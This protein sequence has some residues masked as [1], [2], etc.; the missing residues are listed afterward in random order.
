MAKKLLKEN[1][2]VVKSLKKSMNL[3][4]V[5][6]EFEENG[7][8]H[9]S[10]TDKRGWMGIVDQQ[11]RTV[12]E[13]YYFNLKY[14]PALPEGTDDF[15]GGGMHDDVVKIWHPARP[16]HYVG[17]PGKART[18]AID[19]D[20]IMHGFMLTS[21]LDASGK[22]LHADI[23]YYLMPFPGYY[24]LGARH[25]STSSH[26]LSVSESGHK[27]GLM[28]SLGDI[29]LEPEYNNYFIRFGTDCNTSK[30][31]D[32]ILKHGGL[33]LKQPD[34]VVPCVYEEVSQNAEGKWLV[35]LNK[36]SKQ[37]VWTS[38]SPTTLTYRDDGEKYFDQFQYDDVIS[39]YANEGVGAPWAK[40]FT[41]TSLYRKA[42][43]LL[44]SVHKF[45]FDV[46]GGKDMNVEVPVI[47]FQ[48]VYNQLCFAKNLLEL[49]I[50]MDSE[51]VSL[52]ANDIKWS[53]DW[54]EK[55]EAGSVQNEYNEALNTLQQLK[56]ESFAQ[57]QA[58]QREY[59]QAMQQFTNTMNALMNNIQSG[60]NTS[61][62]TTGSMT[63]QSASGVSGVSGGQTEKQYKKSVKKQVTCST[64]GGNKK[65]TVCR[66]TGKSKATY[67]NGEHK[68]CDACSGSGKC[69]ICDGKGYKEHWE[70]E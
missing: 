23:D 39:F 55:L 15:K 45:N 67:S 29:I 53:Q 42:N 63:R 28:T 61:R 16:A 43:D 57:Q 19:R 10:V 33:N 60:M 59:E 31:V 12:I 65:C 17:N 4:T 34:V 13:P 5:A 14:V 7:G 24:A 51:F 66:G 9:Y 1:A 69:F 70:A 52:A 18:G 26:A 3:K 21:I 62:H 47:D 46:V 50:Q 6:I 68:S 2:G 56:A 11:G 20:G 54:I 25:L 38:A 41:G 22:V 49:Y 48:Q 58:R 32:N 37:E 40:F 27:V 44:N 64:C 8:W 30:W 36:T 35:K